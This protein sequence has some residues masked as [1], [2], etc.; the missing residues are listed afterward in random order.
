MLH[1]AIAVAGNGGEHLGPLDPILVGRRIVDEAERVEV[2]HRVVETESM[3]AG[4]LVLQ[5]RSFR[6]RVID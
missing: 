6:N 4:Q 5:K 1:A 3:A 2:F